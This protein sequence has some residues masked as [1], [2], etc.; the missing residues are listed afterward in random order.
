MSEAE[1]L[2]AQKIQETEA[3]KPEAPSEKPLK[4]EPKY[5][6]MYRYEQSLTP[7]DPVRP[8]ELVIGKVLLFHLIN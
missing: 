5:E 2:A 8:S 1:K 6:L 7:E 3:L 4:K